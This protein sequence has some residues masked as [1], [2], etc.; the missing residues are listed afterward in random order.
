[1]NALLAPDSPFPARIQPAV[2]RLARLGMVNSLAQVVLKLTSPGVPD[3]Y[4]GNEGWD[5]SLVDP[6]NRRPVEYATL[7]R[8]A[9]ALTTGASPADLLDRWETGEIKLALT[10]RLL[11]FRRDHPALFREG[12]Y[13]P[14]EVTGKFAAHAVGFIRES[15]SDRLLV[16][17]PRLTARLPWPPLGSAWDDQDARL[18]ASGRIWTHLLTDARIDDH[19]GLTLHEVFSDLS[20]AV[21]Y[22]RGD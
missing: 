18:P 20:V 17:V 5:F 6:D 15:G 3:L 2:E 1:V 16:L 10:Q 12:S 22:S 14:M 11:R 13:T 7:Q 9:A 19:D 4:Q 8:H 21:L